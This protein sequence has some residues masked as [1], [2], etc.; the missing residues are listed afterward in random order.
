MHKSNA[1]NL[2]VPKHQRPPIFEEEVVRFHKRVKMIHDHV[3]I[4]VPCDVFEAESPI[5]AD[6]SVHLSSYSGAFDDHM[7]VEAS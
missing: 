3:K 6:K 5:P 4:V 7:Y 1:L 2:V